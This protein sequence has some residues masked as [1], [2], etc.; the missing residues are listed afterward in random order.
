VQSLQDHLLGGLGVDSAESLLVELFGLDQL[1]DLGAGLECLSLGHCHL[2]GGI[3][4]LFSY[5]PGAEDAHLAG[6]SIDA[7][8]NI[9][10]TGGTAV[11]RLDRLLDGPDELL[12]RDAL[13][14]VELQEGA[15]EV[16]TQLAP[17]LAMPGHLLLRPTLTTASGRLGCRP[18]TCRS[19]KD[20]GVTHVTSGR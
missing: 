20:V 9:L 18:A 11:R 2:G 8:V 10:V 15:Y 13:L 12:S 7:D 6:F 14:S 5:Q 4:D 19:T 1:A 16:S 17:P 3:V